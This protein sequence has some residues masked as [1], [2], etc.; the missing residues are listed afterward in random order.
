[1]FKASLSWWAEWSSIIQT[2][3]A[4][5]TFI[6]CLLLF[7]DP[8]SRA[9]EWL[10]MVNHTYL[11]I[12]MFLL[13]GLAIFVGLLR[14]GSIERAL[15]ERRLTQPQDS[16]SPEV[17]S[18][19]TDIVSVK[20]GEREFDFGPGAY[21][22]YERQRGLDQEKL[23]RQLRRSFTK[24]RWNKEDFEMLIDEKRLVHITLDQYLNRA[25]S[26]KQ[27]IESER[28]RRAHEPPF[29]EEESRFLAA[30]IP[31][32]PPL[33]DLALGRLIFDVWTWQREVYEFLQKEVKGYAEEFQLAV[34]PPTQETGPLSFLLYSIDEYVERLIRIKSSQ[35]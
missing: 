12:A 7:I 33:P 20:L 6:I 32:P 16:S 21:E 14:L 26:I 29:S 11:Q 25:R 2:V 15:V 27:E 31:L 17:I 23:L 22:Y 28:E 30:G 13:F 10:P 4:A 34:P 35:P 9:A 24:S 8:K 18:R 1:M 5:L 3:F 19:G